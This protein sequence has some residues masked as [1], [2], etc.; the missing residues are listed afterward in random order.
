MLSVLSACGVEWKWLGDDLD[1]LL[2]GSEGTNKVFQEQH[3]A[4]LLNALFS[5][6]NCSKS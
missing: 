1:E 3:L 2:S 5:L 6:R 4:Q